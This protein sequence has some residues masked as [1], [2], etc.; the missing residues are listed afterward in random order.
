[1]EESKK[2]GRPESRSARLSRTRDSHVAPLNRLVDEIRE[3]RGCGL[4]VPYFDPAD[5]GEGAECLFVLEAPGTRAVQSGFVSRDNPDETAKNLLL[6]NA[7]AGIP[8]ELTAIWNIVPWYI[9]TTERIQ[10][11]TALV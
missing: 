3:V 9:G 6:L 2:L 5:G 1:L 8:R 10:A 4:A 11:A 7:E